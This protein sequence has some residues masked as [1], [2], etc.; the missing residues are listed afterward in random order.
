M[1]AHGSP[2]MIRLRGVAV[3]N[4]KQ[5]DLDLPHRRLIAFCGVSGSGKTSLALDTLYT[6]G[7]RRYVESFSTYTRQFLEQLD[8]PAAESI[9]GIPPS[10]A[11]AR[12]NVSRSSRATVGSSTQVNEHLQLLFA[13]IGEVICYECGE[14]VE[15][16]SAESAAD[17]LLRLPSGTRVMLGF[18]S[19]R[20]KER[21]AEEWLGD[22]AALGYRRCVLAEKTEEIR[23]E[24]APRLAE[25]KEIEVVVDRV[26]A[27][28]DGSTRLRDSLES[29]LEAGRG[30]AVAW[31]EASAEG[32]GSLLR[33]DDAIAQE[34]RQSQK[35][36][37]P[38]QLD[39]RAWIVRRFSNR[40]RC[41]RCGI[42][43]P[44][45]EPQLLNY[46]NPLGACKACEGFGNII[47]VDMQRVVPDAEKSLRDG[48]IAPWN[49]PAYA[50]ELEELLALAPKYGIPVDVPFR[51][52]N[53]EHLR[54][55][56]EGVPEKKFGGLTGF[57]N[58]LERRKYKMH[59]RVFLSRWRSY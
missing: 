4:L 22:L 29:S 57:F 28:P 50:H 33:L 21:H 41:E 27:Q 46:N 34:T 6:E 51:D 26:T 49:T 7:Q 18:V 48:A 16:D 43:Y 8:K 10:I 45:V 20:G 24:L 36:P 58:W 52:L 12:K 5:V 54:L 32:V 25:L 40:L 37:D 2:P 47:D 30:A 11:V 59:I 14:R 3:H 56:R 13:R 42:Q 9:E 17:E 44:D 15:R 31:V 1:D 19:Q 38:V 35:T 23:P 39:D 53:E 55:I